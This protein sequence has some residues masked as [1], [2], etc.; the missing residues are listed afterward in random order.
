MIYTVTKFSPPLHDDELS[1]S[2]YLKDWQDQLRKQAEKDLTDAL[3]S[4]PKALLKQH[5]DAWSSIWQSGF[6]ISRSLAPSVMN[7]DV[8]NR[9]LYYVLSST[10]LSSYDLSQDEATKIDRNQSLS[11]IDQ[12]YESHSTL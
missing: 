12:C 1:N 6:A 4:S 7:G 5:V 11:Q 10:P 8:I 2:T 9:T 3:E